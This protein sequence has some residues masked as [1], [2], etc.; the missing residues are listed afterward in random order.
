M[1]NVAGSV[2]ISGGKVFQIVVG[3]LLS[4]D[5]DCIINA[6]NGH[7]AHGG[8]VAAVIARAAGPSLV[9]ECDRL[10]R[11]NGP[12]P[13]GDCVVTTAGNL[14]FKGVIHAVGPRMGEGNEAVKLMMTLESCFC[15][16]QDRGWKS[17]SFPAVSSGIFGVPYDIC[18]R[19]YR[20]AVEN[21][22]SKN[23]DSCVKR[24]RLVLFE[25]PMLDQM[26]AQLENT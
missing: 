21:F 19:A 9:Q 3:D 2:D 12:V 1:N 23:P 25:G 24:I 4:E 14:P 7:L 8:G 26:I 16:A 22:C 20:K 10:V 17:V 6:A 18:A 13:T 11:G 5:T 15:R